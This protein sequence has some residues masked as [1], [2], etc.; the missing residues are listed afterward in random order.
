MELTFITADYSIVSVKQVCRLK[1]Y[2]IIYLYVLTEVRMLF[3]WTV[4]F[5][6]ILTG[7]NV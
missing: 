7:E 2:Q 5:G 4:F 3:D 6:R 1:L